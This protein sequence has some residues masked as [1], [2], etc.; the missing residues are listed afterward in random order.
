MLKI[1]SDR[2]NFWLGR[3]A[4]RELIML[5][6]LGDKLSSLSSVC[7]DNNNSTNF[8][9]VRADKV[10]QQCHSSSDVIVRET[11]KCGKTFRYK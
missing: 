7:K 1:G 3:R 6:L 9:Y 11:F 8:I 2:E 10:S 5:D 4:M